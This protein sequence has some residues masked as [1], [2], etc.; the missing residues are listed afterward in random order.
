MCCCDNQ[1]WMNIY[2]V[3]RDEEPIHTLRRLWWNGCGHTRRH[4][5]HLAS[6]GNNLIL[7]WWIR[8]WPAGSNNRDE[9]VIPSITHG[10]EPLHHA[11]ILCLSKSFIKHPLVKTKRWWR[12][13]GIRVEKQRLL[14]TQRMDC[15]FFYANKSAK[16]TENPLSTLELAV[17]VACKMSS[18]YS[19]FSFNL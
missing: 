14:K 8:S 2:G 15:K 12:I 3:Y 13:F 4:G 19:P 1:Q 7:C 11:E 16:P 6:R 5:A 17:P 9:G 18:S 10:E